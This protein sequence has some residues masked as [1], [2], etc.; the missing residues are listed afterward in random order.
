MDGVER[1]DTKRAI[2][3][4]S[5]TSLIEMLDGADLET[6]VLGTLSVAACDTIDYI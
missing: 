2:G 4:C 1:F 6:C 5:R 3:P